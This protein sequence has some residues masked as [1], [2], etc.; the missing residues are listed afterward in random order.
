[1]SEKEE[2]TK[3]S[4]EEISSD[5]LSSMING[6]GGKPGSAGYN[7]ESCDEGYATLQKPVAKGTSEKDEI[8]KV[9]ARKLSLT[10]STMDTDDR[11]SDEP[12]KLS[13]E[14]GISLL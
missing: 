5:E 3:G 2:N 1:M 10:L 13:F 12:T 4:S 6:S 7:A 8:E 11:R 9:P 14:K